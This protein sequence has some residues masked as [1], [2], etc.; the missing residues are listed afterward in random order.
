MGVKLFKLGNIA[1]IQPTGRIPI[2]P[3]GVRCELAYR[4]FSSPHTVWWASAHLAH[5]LFINLYRDTHIHIIHM[6]KCIII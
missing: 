1:Y 4:S 6:Y 2:R 3:L 5:E